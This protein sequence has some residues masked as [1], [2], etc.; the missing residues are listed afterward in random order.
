M[1]GVAAG[2]CSP[3]RRQM[4]KVVAGPSN[5][6]GRAHGAGPEQQAEQGADEALSRALTSR[7]RQREV[8]VWLQQLGRSCFISCGLVRWFWMEA[9]AAAWKEM[10]ALKSS[11][12]RMLVAEEPEDGLAVGGSTRKIAITRGEAEEGSGT[13]VLRWLS[14]PLAS[15]NTQGS[16]HHSVM[17]I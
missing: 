12:S 6:P 7:L 13:I 4:A 15:T 17:D 14:T 11:S 10:T 8:S 3:W 16:W 1:L 9:A 5:T 2:L